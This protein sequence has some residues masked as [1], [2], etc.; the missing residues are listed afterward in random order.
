MM[1]TATTV[2]AG[3]SFAFA[4]KHTEYRRIHIH[5]LLVRLKICATH[6]RR[7]QINIPS[8]LN[9]IWATTKVFSHLARTYNNQ[10]RANPL[11]WQ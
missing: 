3:A 9:I 1:I 10:T 7:T 6:Y 4:H 11:Q 2:R 5:R 8:C